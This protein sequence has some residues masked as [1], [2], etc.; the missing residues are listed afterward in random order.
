MKFS[1]SSSPHS[2]AEEGGLLLV[3]L[4]LELTEGGRVALDRLGDV[5]LDAVELHCS[6][7]PVVLGADPDEEQPGVVLVSP[8]VD[9]LERGREV[10]LRML[11]TSSLMTQRH[12]KR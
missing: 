5:P 3:S 10:S 2:K 11:D 8:V 1:P 12:S 9:Y 6:D 7:H 4:H